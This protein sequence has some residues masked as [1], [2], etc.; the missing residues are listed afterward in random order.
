MM[1]G[2]VDGLQIERC[3]SRPLSTDPA[4]GSLA[5][6]AAGPQCHRDL[7]LVVLQVRRGASGLR[8]M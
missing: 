4:L 1:T 2:S 3:L 8:K 7:R 5:R 6:E